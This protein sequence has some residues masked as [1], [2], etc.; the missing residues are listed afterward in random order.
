[1]EKQIVETFEL[2]NE[3]VEEFV[4]PSKHY[5]PK[6][7]TQQAEFLQKYPTYDGRGIK[8]AILDTGVDPSC[9][10]LQKTTDGKIKLIECSDLTGAGDV[11]TSTV[12]KADENRILIGLTERELKIPKTWKNPSGDWHLG[13]KPLHE[14][15]S[16]KIKKRIN[17][18]KCDEFNKKNKSAIAEAMKELNEHEKKVGTKS[19]KISD[20]EDREEINAKLELLKG[21]EKFEV[22]SP[23]ADCI[24]WFDGEKWKACLDTSL[25]GD[26]E[27]VKV[28]SNFNENQEYGFLSDNCLMS[29]CL[30]IHDNGNLLEICA[31][32]CDH[33]THVAHIAAGHFPDDPEKDGLAPG[34]QIISLCI[35]DSRDYYWLNAQAFI[36]ALNKCI[37]LKVDVINFS[38]T[39]VRNCVDNGSF[40]KLIKNVVEKHGIIFVA[41]AGNYGPA[42]STMGFAC[43]KLHHSAIYV[44]AYLTAEMKETMY[45]HFEADNSVVFPFSS[46]GP[47]LDG[48]LGVCI[49]APGAAMAGVPKHNLKN[50]EVMAGT[51]MS[52]P[53]AT[54]NIACLLSA[55]KS[56]SVPISPFRI[57]L[58]LTN[59]AMMPEDG[60]HHPFSLGAGIIQISSA[61]ELIKSS[62]ASIPSNLTD[63][64]IKVNGKR[65]IYLRELY[66]VNRIQE[67]NAFV[68]AKF[69][70]DK[71]LEKVVNYECSV[72]LKLSEGSENFVRC[73]KYSRLP[74]SSFFVHVDPT[75][76]EPGKVHYAEV[77]GI[78]PKNRSLGPLFRLPI[79]VIIPEKLAQ[80]DEYQYKKKLTLEPANPHRIFLQTPKGSTYVKVIFKSY[81]EQKTTKF[82]LQSSCP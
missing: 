25:K 66:D 53:N 79:T 35:G 6:E 36:R 27:N 78:D 81:E 63:F 60:S 12:K 76:L 26:L 15:Y 11:D 77:V 9:P 82:M 71:E 73:P 48:T 69:N 46:R 41:G 72:L 4:F 20:I 51:S 54:G 10:G 31:T 67:C 44:G 70:C 42:L 23:V 38:Y 49:S 30:N 62:M 56:E 37:E 55:L 47:C 40:A 50:S 65:G 14:L 64:K 58:G 16:Y 3:E 18:S 80:D 52:A 61:F 19:K 68:K 45:S 21:A 74:S 24:V 22:E 34:A 28:M 75:N 17:E 29:Y 13:I 57:K 5:M 8:I 7:L 32:H 59:S 2:N 33:G 39:T 1:M 43:G